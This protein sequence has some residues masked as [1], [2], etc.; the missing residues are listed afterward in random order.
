MPFRRRALRE[1]QETRRI[2]AK[3]SV[4]A[5]RI[6]FL[7]LARTRTSSRESAVHPGS[8]PGK[9]LYGHALKMSQHRRGL[10]TERRKR[11]DETECHGQQRGT[12]CR[13]ECGK[14]L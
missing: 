5:T 3:E 13:G 14:R 9:L 10:L 1:T 2:V 7:Y 12:K 6:N 11:S 8:C 4:V